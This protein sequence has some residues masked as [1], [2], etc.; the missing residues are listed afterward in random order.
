VIFLV[1]LRETV[2]QDIPEIY[3]YIHLNYVKKYCNNNLEEQWKTHEKWYKFLI[4][5]DSYVLYTVTSSENGKF[6]GCVKFELEGE[7][8][9]V[10][11]Y[12]VE[13]I[14]HK[15]YSEKI[16]EL[17][18]EELKV[19]HPETSIVLAYILEE[20][21]PSLSA[22]RHLGFQYDGTEEY[23]GIDHMLFIKTLD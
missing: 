10:N 11:V 4:H 21:T 3:R 1:L 23:K 2:E 20:N 15:G 22:F 13:D 8:A 6:Y 14:R 18:I 12:L 17:S 16:I 19:K 7:C 5:S 9:I